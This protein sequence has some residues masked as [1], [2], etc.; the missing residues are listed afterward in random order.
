MVCSSQGKKKNAPKTVFLWIAAGI[1]LGTALFFVLLPSAARYYLPKWLV[2]N[3][4]TRATLNNV[5]F[6]PFTGTAA[7]QGLTVIIDGVTVLSD[8]DVTIDIGIA[9]LF[10]RKLTLEEVILQDVT[11]NVELYQDGRIRIGSYT[12]PAT[13]APASQESSSPSWTVLSQQLGLKNCT[14]HFKMPQL[15]FILHL[16]QGKLNNFSTDPKDPSGTFS[17]Q[18]TINGAPLALDLKA[19]RLLPDLIAKGDMTLANFP[20]EALE[21]FL[22]PTLHP[23]T[24]RAS[25]DGTV[26]YSGRAH[27]DITVDYRGDIRLEKGHISGKAFSV[28]A[29]PLRWDKGSVHFAMNQQQGI[30]I[31]TN[32]NLNGKKITVKLPEPLLQLKEDEAILSGPT[33]V[34][35]NDQV[36]VESCAALSLG[37]TSFTLPS[38]STTT[39]E[40]NWQG[41]KKC[42]SFHSG[43]K[44]KDL[45]ALVQGKLSLQHTAFRSQKSKQQLSATSSG[46]FWHG[47]VNAL[48]KAKRKKATTV[49][50]KG[51]LAL[52]DSA[53]AKESLLKAH[54]DSLKIA[55]KGMITLGASTQLHYDG[56]IQGDMLQASLINP[57]LEIKQEAFS[58]TTNSTLTVAQALA[59]RGQVGLDVH[60]FTVQEKNSSSHLV[61]FQRCSIPRIEAPGGSIIKLDEIRTEGLALGIPGTIPLQLTLPKLTLNTLQTDDSALFTV[62]KISTQSPR[63]IAS[64]NKTELAGIDDLEVRTISMGKD[65][66]LTIRRINLDNF[67]FLGKNTDDPEALCRLAS[68]RA[69]KIAWSPQQGIQARSL[70][71]ADLYSNIIREKDGHFTFNT[72]LAALHKPEEAVVASQETREDPNKKTPP[73]TVPFQLNQLTIRGKS[74]LHF[75]DRTLAVPFINNLDFTT[76]QINDID[77]TN[78]EQPV[79]IHGIGTLDKRA[80]LLVN[81]KFTPFSAPPAGKIKIKLKNYPVARLSSY[82]VQSVGVGLGSGTLKIKSKIRLKDNQL[83]IENNIRLKNLQTSTI[84]KELA[85][86]LDNQLP[87]PLDS[88]LSLLRD[89]QGTIT[90]DVPIKGPV[91]KLHVGIADILITALGEAIVPA[92]S[93]YLMYALGPYGAL[94]WVGM[95]VGEQLLEIRLPAVHFSPG[96]NDIPEKNKD[97]FERLAKIL[98]DKPNEDLQLNPKSTAW[99]LSGNNGKKEKNEK[100]TLT[101]KERQTLLLLGQKRAQAIKEA[102]ERN[103]QIDKDR[104]LITTTMIETKSNAQ[105]RVDISM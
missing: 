57:A 3:G 4:A 72:M 9:A 20:L 100:R 50:T 24:G 97:Y 93:G 33:R 98:H 104:L 7:V 39:S 55:G 23:F 29:A 10:K 75:E 59:Y 83:D 95:K 35:I 58:L 16:D 51:T 62:A 91:D 65:Q 11:L 73:G 102:L 43:S 56:R 27:N 70:S 105:P 64:H 22:S 96:E 37:Q 60:G 81:G 86:K 84:S 53:Y 54:Q 41:T 15:D 61:H 82:T 6:N 88:A 77:S 30:V 42:V 85:D 89:N 44:D 12:V 21:D 8:A 74:G 68:A 31:E 48:R 38:F 92:T 40:L 45:S 34:T 79:S 2:E 66:H 101:E 26:Q 18:G 13:K 28:Q 103:Y 99:E 32:G 94:A 76:L 87:L 36:S 90:L 19:L 17:C 67:F 80:P 71:L 69:S 63:L 1:V 47:T 46:L 14:I 49:T 5:D 78:P 52:K 25:L